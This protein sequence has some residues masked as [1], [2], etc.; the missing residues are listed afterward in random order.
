M[1]DHAGLDWDPHV[2]RVI[3][4][5]GVY[6]LIDVIGDVQPPKKS[7]T[8]EKTLLVYGSSITH[9]SNALS[10]PNTWPSVLAHHL[11]VDLINLGMA[12]SCHMEPEML[13]YLARLGEDGQWDSAILELGINALDWADEK[14]VPRVTNTLKQVAGRNPDK[15]IFVISPFYCHDDFKQGGK[16]EHWR[17]R[18]EEICKELAFPNVRY[19]NGKD[20]LGDMSL[21]SADEVHPNIYGVAQIAQR[22]TDI[23]KK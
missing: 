15:Q 11:N 2:L 1:T 10:S 12:G 4:N 14:I 16:A 21:I 20:L 9:G 22:L 19:L 6:R 5:R 13:N 7:Q 3:F 23:L 8:P 17:E 18:I